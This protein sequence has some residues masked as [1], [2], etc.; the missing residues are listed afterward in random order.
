MRLMWLAERGHDLKLTVPPEERVGTSIYSDLTREELVPS[1]LDDC[2]ALIA[3]CG[4]MRTA[5]EIA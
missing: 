4:G 5:Q 1:V 3:I 2:R